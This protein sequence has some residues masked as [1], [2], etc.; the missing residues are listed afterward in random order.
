[1]DLSYG[2]SPSVFGH[3]DYYAARNR[4]NTAVS[5]LDWV[6]SNWNKFS[7]GKMN[8]PGGGGLYDLMARDADM[9]RIM[10]IQAQRQPVYK[11][12]VYNAPIIPEPKTMTTDATPVGGSAMGVKTK[13]SKKAKAGKGVRGTRA[14][15]RSNRNTSMQIQNLNVT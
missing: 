13:R 12:P 5:L 15:A 7:K 2:A 14:L 8:Q 11:P 6:N 3:A 10:K 9:E 1:M 4:G